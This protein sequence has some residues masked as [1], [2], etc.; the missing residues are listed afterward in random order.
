MDLLEGWRALQRDL[1]RLDA[2]HKSNKVRFNKSKC[3]VLH[4]ENNKRCSA[5]GW[6]VARQKKTGGTDG[7]QGGHEPAVCPGC[8]EGQWH[9]ALIRNDVA[10][11]TREV[12][13]LLCSALVRLHL[14][15]CVQLWAPI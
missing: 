11:G 14:E 12:I 1:D 3:L 10:S 4:C 9:L 2:G 5:A 13:V 15:C 6:T 8:Q 7:Q